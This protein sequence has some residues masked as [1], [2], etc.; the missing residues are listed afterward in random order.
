MLTE[1]LLSFQNLQYCTWI[2]VSLISAVVDINIEGVSYDTLLIW[3]KFP[4]FALNWKLL[5]FEEFRS[6]TINGWNDVKPLPQ[7]RKKD[8]Q[9]AY[10]IAMNVFIK[11]HITSNFSP[12]PN[13]FTI[14]FS[15]F[16]EVLHQKYFHFFH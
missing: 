2:D 6:P 14:P 13:Y 7:F 3:L 15:S 8:I 1:I 16:N 12:Y 4:E 11:L 9:I 5:M 10:Q